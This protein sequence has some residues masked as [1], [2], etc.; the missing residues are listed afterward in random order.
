MDLDAKLAVLSGFLSVLH[1]FY[2]T[3]ALRYRK[4]VAFCELHSPEIHSD[5]GLYEKK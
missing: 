1:F 2:T 5:M 3:T 4:S